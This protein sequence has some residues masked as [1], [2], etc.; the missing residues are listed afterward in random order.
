MTPTERKLVTQPHSSEENGIIWTL[1]RRVQFSWVRTSV[2]VCVCEE[3]A[4][5]GWHSDVT[6]SRSRRLLR[7]EQ[8]TVNSEQYTQW[9]SVVRYKWCYV[10]M[11]WCC[12]VPVEICVVGTANHVM[13]CSEGQI[14]VALYRCRT[15]LWQRDLEHVFELKEKGKEKMD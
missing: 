10:E 14:G 5:V 8:W 3:G 12:S 7:Y 4:N 2:R 15:M 1:E 11:K 9:K 13:H 6:D